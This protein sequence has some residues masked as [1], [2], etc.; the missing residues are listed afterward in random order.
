MMTMTT[1]MTTTEAL[2]EYRE[3]AALV[4]VLGNREAQ[5]YAEHYVLA[6]FIREEQGR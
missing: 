5:W 3:L 1:T 2:S 6:L 4:S